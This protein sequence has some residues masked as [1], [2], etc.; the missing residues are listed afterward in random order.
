MTIFDQFKRL[1]LSY[2]IFIITSA[3]LFFLLL[4]R[5]VFDLAYTS[6]IKNYLD[7]QMR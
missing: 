4:Y 2:K 3:G 1:S 5:I 7:S 6:T